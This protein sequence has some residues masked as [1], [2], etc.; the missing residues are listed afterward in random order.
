MKQRYSHELPKWMKMLGV[1]RI[2]PESIDFKWGYF[3]P[4]AGFELVLNR[5]TY[6][7]Q[8]YAINLAL[9]WGKF[10]VYLPFKTKL[11]EGCDMPRYGF[12]IHNDTFWIYKGGDYEDGQCQNQW[13][14]WYLPFF[15]YTFD[16]HWVQ[17]KNREWVQMSRSRKDGLPE[18]YEFRKDG[19]YVE[20]HPYTYTLKSGKVQNRTATC[21]IEKR[22]WHRKWFPFLTMERQ[23]IDI[24][25]SDEVGE[26]SGSWKG[27]TV[28]CSYELKPDETVYE[29]LKRMESERNF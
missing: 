23:V 11:E 24:E 6:F 10:M 3:A 29:C 7:D 8:R 16:G 1:W 14:S 18:G 19:A 9:G 21:T 22:K 26:R 5:G 4:R 17:N 15:S 12:A 25:F 28:G 2:N 13:I 20:T 27:G